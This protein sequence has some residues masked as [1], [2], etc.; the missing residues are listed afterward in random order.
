MHGDCGSPGSD[1][2]RTK[3]ALNRMFAKRRAVLATMYRKSIKKSG[4]RRCDSDNVAQC[5]E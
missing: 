3:L 4:Y 1:E 2:T 5:G